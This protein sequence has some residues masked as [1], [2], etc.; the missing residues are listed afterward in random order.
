MTPGRLAIGLALVVLAG[1]VL[2]WALSRRPAPVVWQG[3]VDAD[4]VKI[5]PTR[6]G[7]LT[8]VRVA[9]GDAV[10]AGAPLFDQD[11]VA[12]RAARDQAA[13]QAEESARQLANL[14]GPGR[15]TEI[16]QAEANLADA[17]ATRDRA[18]A[19]LRRLEGAAPAGAA[20]FQARDQARAEYRSAQ[21]RVD[22][23]RAA[24][25]QTRAPTGRAEQIRAQM[26]AAGAS[27]AAL[28]MADWQL[29]QRHA[30][31]PA[32]G[33]IAD[34]LARPGE[35]VDAGVPVVSLLPP[36]NIF[37]RLFV[38]QAMLSRVHPGD[39][40]ALAC[41]G[42]APGLEGRIDFISPQAEY[43]PPLIYSDESRAKLVYLVQ[44]RP[45]P[46]QAARLNPGQPVTVRPLAAG[47]P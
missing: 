46:D 33:I 12:E 34:V 4:F 9:R 25:A 44:A 22:G 15:D 20:T 43:T 42:C 47:T 3:Y 28:A 21:A 17:E 7:L 29:A 35:V 19:D 38:P 23:L 5:G 36:G 37:I 6:Q 40:V 1:A 30:T 14:Q 41:D 39:P 24:L 31:A 10:A 32:A 45:R 27:R 11:D 16:R 26:A 8:G 18:R 13:R 2:W